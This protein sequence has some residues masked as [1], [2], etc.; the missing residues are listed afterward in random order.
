[1]Y[2]FGV[3]G[4]P[5]VRSTKADTI[6]ERTGHALVRE[7]IGEVQRQKGILARCVTQL[8]I[9]FSWTLDADEW[10]RIDHLCKT[11]ADR[12]YND[13]K[14]RQIRKFSTLKSQGPP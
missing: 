8:E 1:M 4:L 13:T 2:P 9:D 14:R 12:V 7:R 3:G 6:A 5:P 11:A 10:P